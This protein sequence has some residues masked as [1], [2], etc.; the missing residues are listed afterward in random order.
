[1]IGSDHLPGLSK[2]VEESGEANQVIGKIQGMGYLGEHWDGKGGLERRL[3][4]EF[5][6]VIAAIAYISQKNGLDL[7]RMQARTDKKLR[8]FF[9]WHDNIQAGRQPNDDG[10]D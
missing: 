3:E 4:D 10:E 5:A 8:K 6:D 2:Y 1:M 7:D 9:R